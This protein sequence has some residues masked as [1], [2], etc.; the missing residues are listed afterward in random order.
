MSTTHPN[1]LAEHDTP[2]EHIT[3]QPGPP[4]LWPA[5][6][7]VEARRTLAA[8]RSRRNPSTWLL[9]GTMDLLYGRSGSLQKFLILEHLAQ[10]PYRSWERVAQRRIDRTRGQSRLARRI[11]QRVD[12]ARAQHDNEQWHRLVIE[13]L[14]ARSGARLGGF[15]FRVIPRLIAGPWQ[16]FTWLL[17]LVKPS[18]SY[19]LNAAF[20]AHAEREYMTFVAANPGF[21]QTQFVSELADRWRHPVSVADV[22]R[23]IGHD[24]RTHKLESIAAARGR[25]HVDE[26][27]FEPTLIE[28]EAA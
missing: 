16:L 10:M 1:S 9:F 20:E 17:H 6:L 23:Q 26:R 22:L 12:E 11:Q 28:A 7:R 2:A 14:I 4:T 13:D 25:V 24:E 5:E 8:P 21:E 27:V 3:D 15:R 18:W 19:A